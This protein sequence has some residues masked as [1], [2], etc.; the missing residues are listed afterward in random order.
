[1]ARGLLAVRGANRRSNASGKLAC[2]LQQLTGPAQWTMHFLGLLAAAGA[3]DEP[4]VETM[5]VEVVLANHLSK[6]LTVDLRLQTDGAEVLTALP[7]RRR[8]RRE[9]LFD[10]RVPRPHRGATTINVHDG[11]AALPGRRRERRESLF[12]AP[13]PRPSRGAT[14]ITIHD[15]STEQ[16]HHNRPHTEYD[17]RLLG[18]RA[19]KHDAGNQR[20]HD[21]TDFKSKP[22]ADEQF[23]L[24]RVNGDC[25]RAPGSVVLSMSGGGGSAPGSEAPTMSG[26]GE[27]APVSEA[28]SMSCEQE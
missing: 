1:M 13:V 28:L 15:D 8:E 10:A 14:I 24:G 2:K 9:S 26:G 25:G 12:D 20:D 19:P 6:Q 11:L 5:L 3:V 7:G 4:I 22:E 21:P 27:P 23:L 18:D 17:E 16:A